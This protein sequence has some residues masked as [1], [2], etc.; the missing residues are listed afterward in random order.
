MIE[1]WYNLRKP[2]ISRSKHLSQEWHESFI[3]KCIHK[4]LSGFKLT[5]DG[6]ARELRGPSDSGR[7][8]SV[9]RYSGLI[10]RHREW[11]LA[12]YQL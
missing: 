10:R 3:D 8:D 6:I 1:R 4:V 2:A 9:D 12:G 11:S 7:D 5:R